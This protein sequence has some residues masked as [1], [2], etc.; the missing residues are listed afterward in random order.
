MAARWDQMVVD[1]QGPEDMERV[2]PEAGEVPGLEKSEGRQAREASELVQGQ[3][4]GYSDLLQIEKEKRE[5]DI[6]EGAGNVGSSEESVYLDVHPSCA[7]S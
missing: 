1:F 2:R 6:H 7:L 3:E 4:R 5:C